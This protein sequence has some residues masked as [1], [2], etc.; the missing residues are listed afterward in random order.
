MK[1]ALLGTVAVYAVYL[2]ARK[3]LLANAENQGT[4]IGPRWLGLLAWRCL[5]AYSEFVGV[6]LASNGGDGIEAVDP[7][8]RYMIVWHPHGFIS[9]SALFVVSRMAIEGRPHGREYF[10]MVAPALF[11]IPIVSE[12]LM[13]VN[14]RK[15]EKRVVENHLEKGVSIAVQPGGVREQ[16]ISRHDQEQA[17]FPPNLGFLRLAIKYGVDLLPVYAFNENQMFRRLEG[18]DNLTMGVYKKSG[19]GLPF[20][21]AKFGLP[22]AGLLPL[23]TDVHMRWGL[24]VSVGLPEPEPSAE[25][26]EALFTE[27]LL[28]LIALFNKHAVEC[29]PAIVASR[30]LKIIRLD[31]KPLPEVVV[32]MLKMSPSSCGSE[33]VSSSSDGTVGLDVQHISKL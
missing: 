20:M 28:A 8:K 22:M 18:F 3:R 7:A 5:N 27:Y 1:R 21:T 15:V 14:G 2:E 25:R 12:A 32:S 30:G 9:W 26:V 4:R 6:K 17:V 24:P 13:L 23:K 33:S 16:M 19:F 11:R 29:L 31:G 10:A